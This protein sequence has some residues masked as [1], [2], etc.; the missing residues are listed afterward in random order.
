MGLKSKIDIKKSNEKVVNIHAMQP[1]I[2]QYLETII[3]KRFGEYRKKWNAVE[4]SLLLTEFP[5]F[6]VVET[7]NTCNLNCVMCFRRQSKPIERKVMTD[8]L[9]LKILQQAKRYQCPS[10]NLNWNNEPLLDPNIIHR[11]EMAREHGFIDI[12]INT[13]AMLLTPSLSRGLIAAGL[14]RLSVSIDAGSEETY[15]KVRRGGDFSKLVENLE[16]FI[17][18]REQMGAKLPVIRCTFVRIRENENEVEEFI[19]HWQNKADYL[20]IQTY[21]PHTNELEAYDMR[22]L[23][24]PTPKKLLTCTQ[25]FE[26]LTIDVDGYVYPCCSPHVHNQRMTFGNVE[27][28]SLKQM[29][30]S[31]SCQSLQ[32]H[33][34]KGSW[35]NL[36][37]CSDC[38]GGMVGE[39]S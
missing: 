23:C 2:E 22:P 21:M 36:P 7:I 9:Y 16:T 24:D 25:P 12:R 10:I 29:W 3:G 30:D 17:K 14:T 4:K 39:G 26:R 28:K 18:I 6:L 1:E 20:L 27:Q 5:L 13:N 11:I 15:L 34:E 8:E 37:I 35:K 32:S 31:K 19:K 38:F 33:M